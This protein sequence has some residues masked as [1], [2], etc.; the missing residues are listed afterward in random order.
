MHASRTRLRPLLVSPWLSSPLPRLATPL[1]SSFSSSARS[2]SDDR[3]SS[4]W[5]GDAVYFGPPHFRRED[6]GTRKPR[7]TE[8]E[9]RALIR[10]SIENNKPP[11][12]EELQERHQRRVARAERLERMDLTMQLR[13]TKTYMGGF[14]QPRH[15]KFLQALDPNPKKLKDSYDV[16]IGPDRIRPDAEAYT[17]HTVYL[18]VTRY[19]IRWGHGRATRREVVSGFCREVDL[20]ERFKNLNW[21]EWKEEHINEVKEEWGQPKVKYTI[22]AGYHCHRDSKEYLELAVFPG[23]PEERSLK[24]QNVYK[25]LTCVRNDRKRTEA[26]LAENPDAELAPGTSFEE[27]EAYE[28]ELL[29]RIIPPSEEEFVRPEPPYTDPPLVVPFL[30]VTLPTRPLAATVARLCKGFERGLPFMASIPNEDRRDGP[31]LFR[32]LLRLRANRLQELITMLVDRLN[33]GTGGLLHLRLSADDRGRGYEGEYLD[34]GVKP[35]NARGWAEY[36]FLDVNSPVWEGINQETFLASWADMPEAT[37]GPDRKET[38]EWATPHPHAEAIAKHNELKMPE[39]PG[40]DII[41]EKERSRANWLLSEKKQEESFMNQLTRGG[42]FD[43]N[44]AGTHRFVPRDQP[45]AVFPS[46]PPADFPRAPAPHLAR[47]PD[48]DTDSASSSRPFQR[49]GERPLD[50]TPFPPRPQRF[51]RDRAY[52]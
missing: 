7:R 29:E 52:Q 18:A 39:N 20:P 23:S 32:R 41:M 26:L 12:E 40:R 1:S 25:T 14:T 27:L 11:T 16:R 6:W 10:K 24:N 51:D 48:R 22:P 43:E 4:R 5:T 31:A 21:G 33:G 38:T 30:T 19:P 47:D 44:L 3:S 13:E 8:E 34:E 45:D 37:R 36:S 2:D 50:R 15:L 42:G 35:P 49:D 9:K 17:P 28:K 46:S